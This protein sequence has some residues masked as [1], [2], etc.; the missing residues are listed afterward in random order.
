MPRRC[1]EREQGCGAV[2]D[3]RGC[4][5]DVMGERKDTVMEVRNADSL[6]VNPGPRPGLG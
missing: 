1:Y 2:D 5:G 3:G 4:C 6:S